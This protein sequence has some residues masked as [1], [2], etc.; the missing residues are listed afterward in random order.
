VKPTGAGPKGPSLRLRDAVCVLADAGIFESQREHADDS[1]HQ[2][3]SESGA[4]DLAER[5]VDA[6]AKRLDRPAL[7]VV[8]EVV[9][10]E[11]HAH[12]GRTYHHER[13]PE[14]CQGRALEWPK[15]T[16]RDLEAALRSLI[17]DG[18]LPHGSEKPA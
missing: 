17:E 13:D 5:V 8:L 7:R 6:L 4:R 10:D 2:G 16:D 12:I 15:L 14:N 11:L 18:Y 9:T 1:R 3:G